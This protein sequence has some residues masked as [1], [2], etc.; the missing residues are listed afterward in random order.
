MLKIKPQ[1]L[2]IIQAIISLA[3]LWKK[4]H[5]DK[6]STSSYQPSSTTNRLS[7]YDEPSKET[8]APATSSKKG[9]SSME[10]PP[11]DECIRDLDKK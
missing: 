1:S 10:F 3:G 9:F 8:A 5:S 6:K 11:L 4:T 2:L 7:K